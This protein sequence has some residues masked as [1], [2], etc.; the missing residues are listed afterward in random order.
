MA[1]IE[2]RLRKLGLELP[3]FTPSPGGSILGAVQVGN[4]IFTSNRAPIEKGAIAWK[5]KLGRDLEVE[6]GYAAARLACLNAL[7]T[8][9]ELSGS[10]ENLER[11]IKLTGW[12]N[13]TPDFSGLREVLNGA[14][15]LFVELLGDRGGHARSVVGVA[16]LPHEVSI[17]IEVVAEMSAS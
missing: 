8:I 9:K 13:S 16:A 12:I 3:E 2:E 10:L 17:E 11:V 14:S 5:G 7:A 1:L 15:D 4:L 6:D